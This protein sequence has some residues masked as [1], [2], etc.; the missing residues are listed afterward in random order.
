MTQ[1]PSLVHTVGP[2]GCEW[3]LLVA[4]VRGRIPMSA[5]LSITPGGIE[6]GPM[7]P[8]ADP[9]R[10]GLRAFTWHAEDECVSREEGER[11]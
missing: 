3:G 9:K 8:H 1:R 5:V 6:S 4:T 2:D 10:I 7:I 11:E